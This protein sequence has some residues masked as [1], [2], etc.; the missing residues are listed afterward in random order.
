MPADINRLQNAA[1]DDIDNNKK[2]VKDGSFTGC[3]HLKHVF[4]FCEDYNR[5]LVNCSQQ[6]IL[7]RSLSDLGYLYFNQIDTEPLTSE[8]MI[9]KTK[10]IRV[11]LT[12]V[13]WKVPVLK[14]GDREKLKL[15]KIVDS[16]KMISVPFR[17]WELCE[18]PHLPQTKKHSWMVKT[19]PQVEKPRCFLT[20][21][22]GTVSDGYSS[23]FD[24]CSLTNVKA[25]L[26][27]TEYPYENFNESFDSNKFTMFYQNYADFQ[28]YYYEQVN[29]QPYL[30]REK[31][32]KLGPFICIYCSRQ[33]DDVK[34]STVNLRIEIEAE[35]N[36]P[37]NTSAY[38]LIFHD[39]IIQ[40]SPF[41][42]EV[43][44]I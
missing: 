22:T 29:S 14:V 31:F 32:K 3:I 37:I 35:N 17:N 44:K 26:N 9:V 19:C 36:F 21:S 43:R 38:C 8:A 30:S 18:Y 13:L 23:D 20:N 1:W 5:I 11:E 25:Y 33:N 40:Y 16:K 39:R 24:T 2:F 34:T 27:S 28:K 4:G 10:K 12:K 42:G 41:T 6:L 15:L 7:N